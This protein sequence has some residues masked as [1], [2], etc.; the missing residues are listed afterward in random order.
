LGI[1]LVDRCTPTPHPPPLLPPLPLLH[2][3]SSTTAT[4]AIKHPPAP[5]AGSMGKAFRHRYTAVVAV[6]DD[7]VV[8]IIII[9][10]VAVAAAVVIV[11]VFLFKLPLLSLTRAF[12]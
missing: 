1:L 5:A 11:V 6:D 4:A 8:D 2:P 12:A 9:G 3:L 10:P 7:I